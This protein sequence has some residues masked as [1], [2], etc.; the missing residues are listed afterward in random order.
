MNLYYKLNNKLLIIF[1]LLLCVF[2][3][4]AQS[5]AITERPEILSDSALLTLVEQRTFD[6]FYK[7]S[8]PASGMAF[9]RIHAD[10]IYPEHDSDVIATGGSGFGLMN[11]I[12]G[13]ERSFIT[14][15]EFINQITKI[16]VFLEKAE[17][18][19]GMFSHWYYPNG[20]TKPFGQKDDGGDMVESSFLLQ[21]LLC[22]RQY[23]K[24]NFKN[25][26]NLIN[27]INT[28]W[29]NADYSW[30]THGKNV[31]Y[32]HW[33]PDYGWQMNFPIHGFN[34]CLIAYILAASSPAHSIDKKVYVEGWCMN[35]K[36]K[37][38]SIYKNIS[39]PFY[40]QGNPAYGG[41]IFWTQYSFLGLNP[42]GLRDEY[43]SYD[44]QTKNMALINEQWCAD[45]PKNFKGYSDSCWG[46]TASYSVDG[47]TAHAPNMQSD[48]GVITPTAALSSFPY[49]PQQSMKALKYFYNDLGNKIWGKYGFYDA[50]SETA[51]WYPKKY[52]AIDEGTIA[53]MIEN[54][55]SGLLWKLFM[56][57]PEVQQGL[58]KLGFHYNKTNN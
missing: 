1:L 28:I 52:L 12:V 48:L 8:E 38:T 24:T 33:S 43:G 26:N 39:I 35:G 20:H 45:N 55:R 53:P 21:G 42:N 16:I 5:S 32:W 58:N 34:E 22:V 9:E 36:I 19:H 15:R 27:R 2:T 29:K 50:F 10:D 54:Y 23:L 46:L 11:L 37:H 13:C 41:P 56:S 25:E 51:N 6:Y 7:G 17:K 47:Y 57:C 14:K 30:Y 4:K 31:L 44:E 49:T 18:Y 3:A 40:Q